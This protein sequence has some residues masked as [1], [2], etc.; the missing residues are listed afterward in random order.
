MNRWLEAMMRQDEV[1]TADIAWGKSVSY[2]LWAGMLLLLLAGVALGI[3]L[4]VFW[5]KEGRWY[6]MPLI[7]V[8]AT[9]NIS[10]PTTEWIGLQKIIDWALKLPFFGYCI[11]ASMILAWLAERMDEKVR[12]ME[13]K[14]RMLEKERAKAKSFEYQEGSEPHFCTV[15]QLLVYVAMDIACANAEMNAQPAAKEL[16]R[17]IFFIAA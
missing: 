7:D 9:Y 8:L 6:V 5:L 3:S 1:K 17:A 13:S 15:P 2:F 10:P 12:Q 11:L 4:L 14:L 16:R